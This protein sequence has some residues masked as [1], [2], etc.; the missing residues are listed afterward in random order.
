MDKADLFQ[1]GS[2]DFLI[3][4][5]SKEEICSRYAWVYDLISNVITVQ[6]VRGKSENLR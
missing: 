1:D 6:K 5:F 2:Y 3:E 4:N